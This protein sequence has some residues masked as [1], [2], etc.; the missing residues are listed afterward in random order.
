[1]TARAPLPLVLLLAATTVVAFLA[2]QPLV[3][4]SLA[5]G[6]V[7]LALAAGRRA[8]PIVAAGAISAVGLLVLT[9]IL[10]ANGNLIVAELP[11]I[12]LLDGEVTAEELTAGAVFGLRLLTVTAVIGAV[13]VLADQDRMLALAMRLAPRSALACALAA[14]ALPTLRRDAVALT[15]TARARGAALSSGSWLG[16]GRRAAPLVVPLVGSSLERS[17]DVAEAMSARGYG[18]GR[19]ARVAE[20][21]WSRR[22]LAILVSAACIAAAGIGAVALG[23]LGFDFYPELDPILSTESLALAA[24]IL[25]ALGAAAW[26]ARR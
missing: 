6:A 21:P 13:L 23:A 10:G 20:A 17:L 5:L 1:V 19:R 11:R 26:A 9:P 8:L 24:V 14:R 3:V 15:E 25:A 4:V 7:L 2:D 22:D 16:R 12:P 18:A